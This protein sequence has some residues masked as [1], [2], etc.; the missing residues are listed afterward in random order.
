MLVLLLF[1]PGR[2][3]DG[4]DAFEKDLAMIETAP[5]DKA[6]EAF[7]KVIEMIPEDFEAYN[8]RGIARAYIKDYDGA[9]D[10]CTRA[11]NP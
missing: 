8:Y 6:I 2:G 10:D 3:F 4:E 11:L 1:Y 9:I 7:S 5:N